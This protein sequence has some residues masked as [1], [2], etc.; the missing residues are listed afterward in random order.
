MATVKTLTD[1]DGNTRAY[2][3]R[4]RTVDGQP[5]KLNFPLGAKGK[6]DAFAITV[7]ADKLVGGSLDD[8]ARRLTVRQYSM[9]WRRSQLHSPLTAKHV[10]A[11]L[12]NHLNPVLGDLLLAKV[13]QSH[14][15]RWH[16]GLSPQLV[17][18]TQ[19]TVTRWVRTLFRAAVV[20]RLLRSSPFDGWR[21]PKPERAAVRI[22]PVEHFEAIA[23]ELPGYV[24]DLARVG[25]RLGLRPGEL[26]GLCVEQVNWF[27]K[28]INVDRQLRAG[29]V[30]FQLKSDTSA[31]LL[32]V[33]QGTLDMLAAHLAE[34]GP[35]DGG[36]IFHQAR[37]P[38]RLCWST[39]DDAWR[40]A[41]AAAGVDR[42]RMHDMRHF[43]A[44]ALIDQGA[45]PVVV[46]ARLG[47]ARL[48][49]TLDL[50]AHLFPADD[51][52]TREMIAKAFA[53]ASC[54]R[55]GRDVTGL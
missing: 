27:A 47:H 26:A 48:S 24:A 7:E 46:K 15:K 1:P 30:V 20:D 37:S 51:D 52:R 44:S 17:P 35:G 22:W 45:S 9:E 29:E 8:R 13:T 38:Q 3:V 4:W 54:A 14:V 18:S 12:D 21:M 53:P 49:E 43:Y 2:Q 10:P 55:P 36:L 39:V 34:W 42:V 40:R 19:A 11:L 16:K 31:R 41:R 6:A 32:P 33:D 25:P 5:R 50:Y 23:G 28:T